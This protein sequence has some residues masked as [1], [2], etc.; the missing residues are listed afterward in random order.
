MG[1]SY[2]ITGGNINDHSSSL[3]N[4]G[5][6]ECLLLIHSPG[7]GHCKAMEP[8]WKKLEDKI[9]NIPDIN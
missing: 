4:N 3:L 6:E 2:S 1:R 9:N 5:S 7:C 8:E